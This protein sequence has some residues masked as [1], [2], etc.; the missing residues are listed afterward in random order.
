MEGLHCWKTIMKT[1]TTIRLNR[2]RLVSRLAYSWNPNLTLFIRPGLWYWGNRARDVSCS[3]RCWAFTSRYSNCTSS[4][5]LGR[6]RRFAITDKHSSSLP[7]TIS[8]RGLQ[9]YISGERTVT[10]CDP[11]RINKPWGHEEDSNSE[12]NGWSNLNTDRN[13]PCRIWLGLASASDIVGT[14]TC[15][16]CQQGHSWAKYSLKTYQSSKKPWFRSK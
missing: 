10:E 9:S 15:L 5:S 11:S 2:E 7:F 12:S 14:I 6:L 4:L 16:M 8:Q 13:Q 1:A 3:K